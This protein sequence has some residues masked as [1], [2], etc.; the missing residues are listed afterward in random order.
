M[1]KLAL[2]FQDTYRCQGLEN[3]L[4]PLRLIFPSVELE[5]DVSLYG[6]EMLRIIYTWQRQTPLKNHILPYLE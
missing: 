6:Y 1:A 4:S 5:K 2:L 3:P